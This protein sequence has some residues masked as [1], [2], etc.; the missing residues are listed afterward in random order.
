MLRSKLAVLVVPALALAACDPSPKPT[1]GANGS[2][3]AASA[4]VIPDDDPTAIHR[5][6]SMLDEGA[7]VQLIEELPPYL[8][9]HPNSYRGHHTLG[10]AFIRTDRFDEA[11]AAFERALAIN[12]KFDN[13]YVGQGVVWR[14][15]GDLDKAVA[16]YQKAI[17]IAPNYPEAYSSLVVI[18]LTR[19]NYQ[20]AYAL[21]A[22]AWAKSNKKDPVIA[23]NYAIACH[24]ANDEETRDAMIATA[25]TLGYRNMGVIDDIVAGVSDPFGPAE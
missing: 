18:E 7:Y 10:W 6:E 25:R 4:P 19:G 22:K 3:P 17:E 9:T 12:P 8:E 11:L 21:G 1:P 23:A 16:A 15:R 5:F 24:Y 13:S 20:D 2:E 14:E